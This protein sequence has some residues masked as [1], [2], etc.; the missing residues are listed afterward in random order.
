MT[1][2]PAG[3]VQ[4]VREDGEISVLALVSVLLRRRWVIVGLTVVGAALGLRSAYTKPREYVSSA[5]FIVPG[6]QGTTSGLAVAASQFGIDLGSAGGSWG[7]AMYVD[8]IHSRSLLEPI[9]FDTIVVAEQGG[10]RMTFMQLLGIRPPMTERSITSAVGALNSAISASQ[11]RA[12]GGVTVSVLAN[13]VV[14]RV[15]EFNLEVRKSQASA[16]LQFAVAQA[17]EAA[18]ALKDA[19][20]KLL[21]FLQSNRD[22]AASPALTFQRDRLQRE[23]SRRNQLYTSWLQNREDA[24]V[25]EVRDTPVIT[26]VENPQLPFVAVPR[27][28]VRKAALG[29][30]GGAV[31]GVFFAFLLDAW[32]RARRSDRDDAREFFRLIDLATPRVFMRTSQFVRARVRAWRARRGGP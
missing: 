22:I 28:S 27:Q 12:L 29:G 19:E 9:L 24:R 14:Q 8:L 26:E 32:V 10:R 3:S 25:R 16:E 21:A 31:V 2:A 15:N 23:V 13:L 20:D 1:E 6:Q 30:I 11:E 4:V 7:P 5:T 17:D 18:Q